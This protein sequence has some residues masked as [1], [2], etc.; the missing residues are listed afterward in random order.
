LEL[1]GS[2][3]TLGR[4]MAHYI[5]E[6]ITRAEKTTGEDK[7]IVEHDCS[8]AILTLW[9]HR[10][11][12]PNGSRPFEELEPIFR[13]VESLDPDS[14][15]PRY[16]RGVRPPKEE[17][18]ATTEQENWLNLVAG[19]DYSAK[20][21]IG[22]CLAEAAGAS[23]DK[24]KEWVKLAE[25][26]DIDGA[27]ELVIR[28]ISKVADENAEIDPHESLR[29]LLRDRLTRLRGFLKIGETLANTLDA[30]LQALSP[31]KQDQADGRQIVL[32]SRPTLPD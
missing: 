21:L 3:D 5:A 32:F 13:A 4:W 14:D 9:R 29:S 1:E 24:S 30:N 2:F 26:I 10:S 28:F 7:S 11:E 19:L 22:Y 8:T 27:P 16:F 25:G 6:L 12:L 17:T 20:V 23:L 15:V 18:P 31:T